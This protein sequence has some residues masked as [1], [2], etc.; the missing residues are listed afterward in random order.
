MDPITIL[1]ALIPAFSDGAKMMFGKFFGSAQPK[2]V[3]DVLKLKSSDIEQMKAVAALDATGQVHMWV[4]DVRAMQRPTAVVMVVS[5]WMYTV[6]GTV[7]PETAALVANLA[8][9]VVFYLFGDRTYL[10]LKKG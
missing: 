1:A 6:I 9:S 2:T 7:Q 3:D 8:S 5:A 4:N 10:G